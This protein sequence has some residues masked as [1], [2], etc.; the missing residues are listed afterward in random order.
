MKEIVRFDTSALNRAFIGLDTMFN[1]VEHRLANQI[2]T[3][4]PPYN[5][6]KHDE[7][8]Y[9]VQLAVAGFRQDEVDITVENTQLMIKGTKFEEADTKEYLYRG[10]AARDFERHFTLGQYLEVA[11]AEIKDGLLIVKLKRNVPEA[12]KPRKID[13]KAL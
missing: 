8:N 2:Q 3:N 10:L 4:Y 7:D 11:G 6:I 9:E 5:V 12:M 1:D 13:I